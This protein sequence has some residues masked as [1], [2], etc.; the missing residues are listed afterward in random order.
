MFDLD[1]M[2]QVWAEHD[3]KL[4]ESIR[5]NR[6]LLSRENLS[7]AR[8]ELQRL[9]VLLGMEAAGWFLIMLLLGNF[10]YENIGA[11][12]LAS[13][14]AALDVYAIGM[15]AA[16]IRQMAAIRQID[17]DGPVTAIQKQVG[18]LRVLRIRT[19]Q[20]ALLAGTV[21]WAPFAIVI[22]NVLFGIESYNLAWLGANVVFGLSLIPLAIWVS[23]RFSDRMD[24]SRFIQQLMNDIAGYNLNAAEGFLIRLSE[25]EKT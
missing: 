12:R 23:K 1:D 9:A 18:A 8:S 2:K 22:C 15:F 21:V 25:F 17:Y 16:L 4:D 24:N 19:T 20:R 10:I 13:A 11:I 14:A 3:R 7:G 6:Q 5:L